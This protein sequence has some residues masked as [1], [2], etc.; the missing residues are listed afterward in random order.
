MISIPSLGLCA[1]DRIWLRSGPKSQGSG[2]LDNTY[3]TYLSAVPRGL[4]LTAVG[5]VVGWSAGQIWP[6]LGAEII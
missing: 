5:T 1:S 6:P 2:C 3:T 4:I